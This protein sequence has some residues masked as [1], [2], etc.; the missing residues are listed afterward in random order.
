MS[1]DHV[2]IKMSIIVMQHG[3][4]KIVKEIVTFKTKGESVM[5]K[6]SIVLGLLAM[7]VFLLGGCATTDYRGP[8]LNDIYV[9]GPDGGSS[10]STAGST[11]GS[12]GGSTIP[13]VS[14]IP[15]S[16]V[17]PAGLTAPRISVDGAL[18]PAKLGIPWSIPSSV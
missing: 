13:S 7:A 17:V 8:D 11:G 2:Y 1:C 16:K 10:G 6:L 9:G 4:L 18:I 14:Y 3:L 15:R 5:K 12:T